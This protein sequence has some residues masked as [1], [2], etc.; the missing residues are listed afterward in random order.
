M[1]KTQVNI[2]WNREAEKQEDEIVR[3]QE[4]LTNVKDTETSLSFY[5]ANVPEGKNR[6]NLEKK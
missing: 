1:T 4:E 6:E 5:F 3:L 2:V